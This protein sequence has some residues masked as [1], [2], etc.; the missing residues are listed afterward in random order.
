[1]VKFLIRLPPEG[2][3]LRDFVLTALSFIAHRS[4]AEMVLAGDCV[5]L[6]GIPENMGLAYS[7]L[8]A[9]DAFERGRLKVRLFRPD[10]RYARSTAEKL[11]FLTGK[12]AAT[13]D[14]AMRNYAEWVRSGENVEKALNSLEKLA[15]LGSSIREGLLYY[16]DAPDMAA[17]QLF[18]ANFYEM[19][20]IFT[21]PRK[22]EIRL[23]SHAFALA[24]TGACLSRV[25]IRRIGGEEEAT[26]YLSLL[27]PGVHEIWNSFRNLLLEVRYRREP[28]AIFRVCVAL[29]CYRLGFAPLRIF[30]ISETGARPMLVSYHDFKSDKG[31]VEFAGRLRRKERTYRDL[32]RLLRYALRRWAEA[33]RE[34]RPVVRVAYEL[35][36]G[37]CLATSGVTSPSDLLYSVARSTYATVGKEF[38][39]SLERIAELRMDARRFQELLSDIHATL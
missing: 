38:S 24:L 17:L 10:L 1:M 25:G 23:D 22:A 4:G 6:G 34:E 9:K 5:E 30:E 2:Y 12:P 27:D 20:R 29:T 39:S 33:T 21:K 36:L 14:N 8:I 11:S 16:G 19:K 35:A 26:V 15:V 32:L 37:I 7:Q 28:E 31:L 18:K 3:V 13:L